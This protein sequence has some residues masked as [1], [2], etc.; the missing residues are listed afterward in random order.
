MAWTSVLMDTSH[1]EASLDL[2]YNV[3][4]VLVGMSS[5]VVFDW[6]ETCSNA[7][8]VSLDACSTEPHIALMTAAIV[9]TS[10]LVCTCAPFYTILPCR[11][12]LWE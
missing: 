5:V 8:D 9:M 12:M 2:D 3:E 1:F 11:I 6:T 4:W 7:S 10:L